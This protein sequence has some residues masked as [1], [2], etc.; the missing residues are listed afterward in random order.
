MGC[1]AHEMVDIYLFIFVFMSLVGITVILLHSPIFSNG[2]SSDYLKSLHSLLPGCLLHWLFNPYIL[3]P[4][5]A[6]SIGCNPRYARD[7]DVA[8]PNLWPSSN[9]CIRVEENDE[10][11]SSAPTSHSTSDSADKPAG[12]ETAFQRMY[13]GYSTRKIIMESRNVY[14]G[15]YNV[16][17]II[18]RYVRNVYRFC[19]YTGYVLSVVQQRR[20]DTP[21]VLLCVCERE[22]ERERGL[23]IMVRYIT[24]LLIRI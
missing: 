5:G 3:C 9:S 23:I 1:T 10:A 4:Q 15:A 12:D 19:V 6:S 16:M 11:T 7:I 2:A 24:T 22:R 13:E 21:V 17:V 14:C 8:V 20:E 18:D